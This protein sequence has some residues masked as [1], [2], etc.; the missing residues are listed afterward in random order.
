[1]S[2]TRQS[3]STWLRAGRE[4]GAR[5]ARDVGEKARSNRFYARFGRI[6]FQRDLW[7]FR[8][9][10]VARGVGVGLFIA[11]TPTV[12]IQLA[13][14][15]IALL[16]TR[17][18]LPT[19]LAL[20]ALTNPLTA[21]PIYYLEYLLG[22]AILS[23]FGIVVAPLEAGDSI[24]STIGALGAATWVGALFA[25]TICSTL[26]YYLIRALGSV[27]RKARLAEVLLNRREASIDSNKRR[28]SRTLIR[29]ARRT[30]MKPRKRLRDSI[31]TRIAPTLIYAL[32]R[33]MMATM[34]ARLFG[35]G[36]LTRALTHG[37]V[38][39]LFW[40]GRSFFLPRL[41]GKIDEVNITNANVQVLLSP[42]AD[43]ELAMA[44]ARRFG[45]K[46]LRGSGERD[47]AKALRAMARA[48]KGGD[49]IALTGDGSRGPRRK[50]RPG[51][52][53]ASRL[54][55]GLNV[56]PISFG[57]SRAWQTKSWDKMII[58]KPFARIAL[59]IGEP[60]S[61]NRRAGAERFEK[62][63]ARLE[64]ELNA[65]DGRADTMARS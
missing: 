31:V 12:G 3:P 27:E 24:G 25:S 48:L 52:L 16:F 41:L 47:G 42:S 43:G 17:G 65:T 11:L 39:F 29:P 51:A 26:G 18:N 19:A 35:V 37:P 20:T 59:A 2:S 63:M 55:D 54:T 13:L 23:R 9:E 64:R 28:E 46:A 34:R 15:S 62:T 33:I 36:N 57:A 53:A 32:A 7:S 49:C 21:G 4:I 10:S 58:P 1:M 22:A 61:I 40:H 56:V 8:N 5:M 38:I 44:L 60:I 50:L 30:E 6:F 14:C 45:L